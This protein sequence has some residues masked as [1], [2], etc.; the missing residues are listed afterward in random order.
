MLC[1]EMKPVVV[2]AFVDSAAVDVVAVVDPSLLVIVSISGQ[3]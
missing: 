2:V 3:D 1:F